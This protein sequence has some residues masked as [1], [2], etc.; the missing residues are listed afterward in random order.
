M[1]FT[2]D[3]CQTDVV[4]NIYHEIYVVASIE[5]QSYV[6]YSIDHQTYVA[7]SI[8]TSENQTYV[9]H[10]RYIS[11]WRCLQY[12]PSNVRYLQH[13]TIK[14]ILFI[15]WIIK[16]MLFAVL[17]HQSYVFLR[18]GPIKLRLF[19][20]WILLTYAVCNMDPSILC[21]LLYVIVCLYK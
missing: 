16:L 9:V 12:W 15:E 10:A 14:F 19:A 11:N 21:C 13:C 17:T 7:Y 1:L 18:N 2:L 20:W 4:Y 5:H 3:T 8:D 6:V